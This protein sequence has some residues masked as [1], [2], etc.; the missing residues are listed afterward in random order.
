MWQ[1][2]EATGVKTVICEYPGR[3]HG[4]KGQVLARVTYF[5]L[6]TATPRGASFALKIRVAL[7]LLTALT[8]RFSAAVATAASIN[9]DGRWYPFIPK[10]PLR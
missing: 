5:H 8:D 3:D 2:S 4:E 9:R 6:Q 7:A 10:A 1:R